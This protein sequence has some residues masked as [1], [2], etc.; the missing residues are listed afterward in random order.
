M[1]L[2][3]AMDPE[4]ISPTEDLMQE[5]GLLNRILL[6]YEASLPS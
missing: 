1:K 5:H 3:L 6:I 4:D 2:I